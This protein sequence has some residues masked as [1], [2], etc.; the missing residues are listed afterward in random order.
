MSSQADRRET[1]SPSQDALP[2]VDTNAPKCPQHPAMGAGATCRR[3]GRFVCSRCTE[4]AL[5]RETITCPECVVVEARLRLPERLK[6]YG[7]QLIASWLAVSVTLV[8]LVLGLAFFMEQD[9]ATRV[10]VLMLTAPAL[11]ILL[12]VTALFAATRKLFFGW[13]ATAMESLMLVPLWVTSPSWCTAVLAAAPIFAAVR[14][15]QMKE[16]RASA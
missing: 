15:L 14:L 11:L 2:V 6:S 1:A 16:L 5:R 12:L 10:G 13:A 9:Q 4:D 3:C 8:T 7:S